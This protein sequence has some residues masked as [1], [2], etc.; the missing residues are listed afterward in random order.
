[1]KKFIYLPLLLLT[2][3]L[4]SCGSGLF[5]KTAQAYEDATKELENAGA[6]DK[7]CGEAVQTLT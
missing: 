1:M 5:D 4:A 2:L 3:L 6:P 7:P